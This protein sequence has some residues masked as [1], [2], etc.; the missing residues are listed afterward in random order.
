VNQKLNL[1]RLGL[2]HHRKPLPIKKTTLE[3]KLSK[4]MRRPLFLRYEDYRFKLALGKY[5]TI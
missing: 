2:G 4:A 1:Q 3:A 5:K